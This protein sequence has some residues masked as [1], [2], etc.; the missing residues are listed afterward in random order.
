MIF[1]PQLTMLSPTTETRTGHGER[2]TFNPGAFFAPTLLPPSCSLLALS[3]DY[4]PLCLQE[5]PVSR[6][7]TAKPRDPD[8]YVF[9]DEQ[10]AKDYRKLYEQFQAALAG[11]PQPAGAVV[12]L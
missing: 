11:Q 6:P 12:G 7:P 10:L 9:A 3:S 4:L 8:T 2:G 1:S 5:K